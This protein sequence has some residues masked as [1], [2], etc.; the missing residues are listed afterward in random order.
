M[1]SETI[2]FSALAVLSSRLVFALYSIS[3]GISE[4]FL[5][6]NSLGRDTRTGSLHTRQM[7]VHRTNT[8][9]RISLHVVSC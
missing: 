1:R 2:F 8:S 3:L 5:I 9:P 7:S 6:V 4:A